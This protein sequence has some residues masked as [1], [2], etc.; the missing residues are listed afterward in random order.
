MLTSYLP[1]SLLVPSNFL[2]AALVLTVVVAARYFLMV[3]LAW[4]ALYRSTPGS[5]KSRQIYQH[6][7]PRSIQLF[8]IRTSLISS[9][10]FGFSGVLIGLFWELGWARLYLDFEA[11]GWTYLFVSF[12]ILAA[13]HEIYFYFTHRMLHEPWAYR[14]FHA[15]HHKSLEPS[16]WA[17]FSFHPV[18]ALIQAAFLPLIVLAVPVHPV[19]LIAYLTVMT[20]SAIINH[21]GFEVL[22]RSAFGMYL[23]RWIIT[24]THHSDHHRFFK[25][26]FGLYV[27][28]LDRLLKT[29][30][31]RKG[32]A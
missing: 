13:V 5:W 27:T 1:F 23:Q 16:P 8:E 22:P 12:F 7:P 2:L 19:V 11:F 21:L 9:I 31:E 24:G 26:N 28:F 10:I 20:I 25:S 18:E 4:L 17:S 6:L 29:E 32:R 3:G 14:R 15:V 30:R